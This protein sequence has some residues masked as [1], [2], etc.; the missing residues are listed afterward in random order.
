MHCTE[1]GLKCLLARLVD[2]IIVA[3]EFGILLVGKARTDIREI[4]A[5]WETPT[6]HIVHGLVVCLNSV[7]VVES[8][9][10]V[11]RN[12]KGAVNASIDD[13]NGIDLQGLGSVGHGAVVGGELGA[14]LGEVIRKDRTVMSTVGLAPDAECVAGRLVLGES[15][16]VN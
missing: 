7:R 1:T 4:L 3:L 16:P 6:G 13:A 8:E 2:L 12:L 10:W 9:L 15:I 14:L 5:E 11:R